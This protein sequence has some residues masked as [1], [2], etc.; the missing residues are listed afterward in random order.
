[1]LPQGE[2]DELMSMA[3]RFAEADTIQFPQ[4]GQ[5][6]RRDL[7]SVDARERFALDVTRS[8]VRVTQCT[9]QERARS[10]VVLVR[11]DVDG[12]RHT[13]PNGAVLECPHIHRYREGYDDK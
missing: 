5:H 9:Y 11:L 2:A 8:H 7:I 12:P 6:L 4:L 10:V 1:M 13:N 3:K